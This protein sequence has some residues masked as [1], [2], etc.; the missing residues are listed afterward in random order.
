MMDKSTRDQNDAAGNP[1]GHASLTAARQIAGKSAAEMP[2]SAGLLTPWCTCF[3]SQVCSHYAQSTATKIK[4]V[5]DCGCAGGVHGK[6]F[7][8]SNIPASDIS[9]CEGW[10]REQ[11]NMP[12]H[13]TP[14]VAAPASGA[15]TCLHLQGSAE[16]DVSTCA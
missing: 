9:G 11:F 12:S 3:G 16:V 5:N 7:C 1:I 6:G 4:F 13:A 14:G 15:N 2:D 8:M 10:A